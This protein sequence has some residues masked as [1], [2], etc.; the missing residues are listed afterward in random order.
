M[1]V[2]PAP[3]ARIIAAG[4]SAAAGLQW[5]T[6]SLA[7]VYDV[8]SDCIYACSFMNLA[9]YIVLACKSIRRRRLTGL[10]A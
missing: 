6:A 4:D 1:V 2:V 10:T 3:V 9:V 8:L 7:S 5:S